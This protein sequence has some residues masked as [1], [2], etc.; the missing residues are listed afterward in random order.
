[1]KQLWRCHV[2]NDVH[3]GNKPP[4][5]CPTCGAKNAFVRSDLNETLEIIGKEHPAI[6]ARTDVVAAWKQFS[7][8]SPTV[9]LT[10]K[11][12]EIEI[13]SQGVLENLRNRGQRYCPCRITTGDRK[14]DL[15]LICPCN[16][17]KQQTYKE[18]GEC[19]CGLFV[20]RDEQ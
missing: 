12:D 17:L 14:K 1:M 19:W 3:L 6:E 10:D 4:D 11:T 18:T 2:C 8:Q 15:N 13:L 5:V 7:D 20:K 16:F 9:K